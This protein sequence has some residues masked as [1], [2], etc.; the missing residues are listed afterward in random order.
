MKLNNRVGSIVFLF[1][2]AISLSGCGNHQDEQTLTLPT[3]PQSLETVSNWFYTDNVS[4]L[5][6]TK[7]GIEK[8]YIETLLSTLSIVN[9]S[10]I[11]EVDNSITVTY[12]IIDYDWL[13]HE[14]LDPENGLIN[15]LNNVL[16]LSS[17]DREITEYCYSV[18]YGFVKNNELQLV[19]KTVELALSENKYSDNTFILQYV[20]Q[21]TE[22]L[23]MDLQT[24]LENYEPTE[25]NTSTE[26]PELTAGSFSLIPYGLSVSG[27]SED[28]VIDSTNVALKVNALYTNSDA[29]DFLTSLSKNNAN[30]SYGDA[31]LIVIDYT[32]IATEDCTPAFDR[33]CYFGE[34]RRLYE[35]S[36]PHLM[37]LPNVTE[38][39]KAVEQRQISVL[40]IPNTATE[41]YWYDEILGNAYK[42]ALDEATQKKVDYSEQQGFDET[43]PNEE[44]SE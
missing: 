9:Y 2:L 37:N 30:L 22:T 29:L 41:V 44:I 12:Q 43:I 34:D 35:T 27:E 33:F 32:I 40:A 4:T 38:I 3:G 21:F 11:A 10:D 31:T 18:A 24:T 23:K 25:I 8:K 6:S 36:K 7:T 39:N 15:D 42:V 19:S 20:Q 13:L 17:S 1:L 16:K 5:V 14:I 28:K 26:N